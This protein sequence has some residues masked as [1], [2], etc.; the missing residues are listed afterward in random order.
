CDA[1]VPFAAGGIGLMTNVSI[2]APPTTTLLFES[3]VEANLPELGTQGNFKSVSSQ[4]LINSLASTLAGLNIVAYPANGSALGT[5]V[6]V[7][8]SV[9]DIVVGL[10]KTAISTV[11]SP[12]L[13]PLVTLLMENLGLDLAKTEVSANLSCDA[14]QG[15]MLMR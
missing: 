9:I 8:G 11:L 14:K 10:L 3:P 15:V 5:T 4:Q 12:I 1:R 13:D 7:V 2:L 6:M